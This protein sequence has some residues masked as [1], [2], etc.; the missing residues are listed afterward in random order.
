MSPA[1]EGKRPEIGFYTQ[2]QEGVGE[3]MMNSEAGALECGP[4]KGSLGPVA[5]GPG[6]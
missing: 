2:I 6:R 3:E 5:G 4:S 1:E